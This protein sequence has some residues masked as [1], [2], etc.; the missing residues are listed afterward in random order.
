MLTDR[1]RLP[2]M[3]AREIRI[4]VLDPP[5]PKPC[6]LSWLDSF[7]MQSFTGRSDFDETSP[8]SAGR[9]EA[10]FR[11]DLEALR[12]DMEDWLARKFGEGRPVKL[13]LTDLKAEA[14]AEDLQTSEN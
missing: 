11:V 14:R 6:P 4:E 5:G 9:L 12:I 3:F 13:R 2:K 7:C 10:S 8:V 1:G